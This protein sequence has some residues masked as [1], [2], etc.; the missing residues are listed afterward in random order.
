MRDGSVARPATIYQG[1][2]YS[3]DG[4]LKGVGY[5]LHNTKTTGATLTDL[6]LSGVVNFERL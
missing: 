6:V 1:V 3:V 4:V 2:I 5:Y